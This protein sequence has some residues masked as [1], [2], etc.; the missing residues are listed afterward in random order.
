MCTPLVGGVALVICCNLGTLVSGWDVSRFASWNIAPKT[1]L[2][3]RLVVRHL[4]KRDGLKKKER[5]G[6]VILLL[7]RIY[8]TRNCM[9]LISCLCLYRVSS[10]KYRDWRR[11]HTGYHSRTTG[12][13]ADDSRLEEEEE[14]VGNA[15]WL[16]YWCNSTYILFRSNKWYFC[17][18]EHEKFLLI[19]FIFDFWNVNFNFNVIDRY[20]NYTNL[21]LHFHKMVWFAIILISEFIELSSTKILQCIFLFIVASLLSQ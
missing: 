7:R 13:P 12:S 5:A 2:I 3:S 19:Y 8:E 11:G 14:F 16:N 21:I 15:K 9:A 10:C 1:A 17:P 20:F 4:R 6:E 18:F